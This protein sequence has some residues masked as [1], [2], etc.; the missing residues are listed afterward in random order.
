[1][2]SVALSGLR[3]ELDFKRNAARQGVLDRTERVLAERGETTGG[4]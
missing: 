1:M 3:E 4:H 2:L